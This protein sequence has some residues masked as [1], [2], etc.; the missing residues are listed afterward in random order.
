MWYRFLGRSGKLWFHL[1][2]GGV[3]NWGRGCGDLGVERGE[4]EEFFDGGYAAFGSGW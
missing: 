2:N 3:I 1:D 4:I